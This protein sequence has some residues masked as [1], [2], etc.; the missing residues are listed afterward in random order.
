MLSV[1]FHINQLNQLHLRGA[2][3]LR[4]PPLF[5]VGN[6]TLQ[7]K[8]FH[9]Q[10]KKLTH[11]N[12]GA[13]RAPGVLRPLEQLHSWT[14]SFGFMFVIQPL[15]SKWVFINDWKHWVGLS[16]DLKTEL[17]DLRNYFKKKDKWRLMVF[18]ILLV[19]L[20]AQ[21]G[22]VWLLIGSFIESRLLLIGRLWN[23]CIHSSSCFCVS[24]QKAAHDSEY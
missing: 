21:G 13:L 5:L 1:I 9:F 14:P 20:R 3:G 11:T 7:I 15:I 22:S 24:G 23:I 16:V 6:P 17:S 19:P 4:A 18:S 10:S 12:P 8:I 2:G